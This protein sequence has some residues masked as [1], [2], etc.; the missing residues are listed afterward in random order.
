MVTVLSIAGFDPSGG[1]GVLADIKTF[2]AFGCFGAAVI[3]SLTFQST[4]G[5][6]GAEHQTGRVIRGQIDPL[7]D[8]YQIE[9]IKIGM[10]PTREAIDVVAEVIE[11]HSLKNIVVDPVMVSTSGHELVADDVARHLSDR[12]FPL[13]DLITPNIREA[14]ALTGLEIDNLEHMTAAARR[15]QEICRAV[16]VKG[17]HLNDEAADVLVQ[18]KGDEGLR[19]F[20]AARVQT[21]NTHGTGCTLSSAITALLASGNDLSTA[22]ATAKAY[23]TRAI[24]SAPDLG[25]GAGPL[26]HYLKAF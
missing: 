23:V 3:T 6:F 18:N 5:V 9:G 21:R 11:K 12:L 8:D 19:I 10:L 16:L 20:R 26:N 2:A 1:A 4:T 13:A 24:Q 17:G 25:H 15:L 14:A 22:V 7:L